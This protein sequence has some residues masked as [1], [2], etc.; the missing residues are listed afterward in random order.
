MSNYRCGKR[1]DRGGEFS[2]SSTSSAARTANPFIFAPDDAP[3]VLEE[4]AHLILEITLDLDELGGG[5]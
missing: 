1:L 4:P 2:P 3:K 5:F